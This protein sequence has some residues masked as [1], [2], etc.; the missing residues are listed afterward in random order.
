MLTN[1]LSLTKPLIVY[2]KE[3]LSEQKITGKISLLR[4]DKREK[5]GKKMKEKREQIER[6]D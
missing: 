3:L 4:S 1:K 6:K 5:K 2:H